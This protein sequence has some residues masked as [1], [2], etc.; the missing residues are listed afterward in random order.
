MKPSKRFIQ[1]KLFLNFV[2][3]TVK[4]ICSP[5]FQNYE[6]YFL[7]R[8][9]QDYARF[10]YIHYKFTKFL[11]IVNLLKYCSTGRYT[12]IYIY[13]VN[14]T[15]AIIRRHLALI[16]TIITDYYKSI[17]QHA[18]CYTCVLCYRSITQHAGCYTCVLC[19]RSITQHAGGYLYLRAMLQVYNTTCWLLFIPACY[20]TGL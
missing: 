14:T 2:I 10:H 12:Y 11:S 19:Y 18:G 20:V 3:F 7:F 6:S 15:R 1:K 5:T 13:S 8:M 16:C 17:T 9:Q 4:K